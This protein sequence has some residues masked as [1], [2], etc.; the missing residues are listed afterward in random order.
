[1]EKPHVKGNKSE[2]AQAGWVSLA[3]SHQLNNLRRQQ[4]SSKWLLAMEAN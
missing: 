3:F 1:M 4:A 2:R